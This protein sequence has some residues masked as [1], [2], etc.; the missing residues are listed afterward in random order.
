MFRALLDTNVI[1][2][3]TRYGG[4]PRECLRRGLSGEVALVA[5][6]ELLDEL[7]RTLTRR[8]AMGAEVAA[9]IRRDIESVSEI[10]D[11]TA[12][13]RVARDPAD[14]MVVAAARAGNVDHL[15]TGDRDLLELDV[16][17][18]SIVTPRRFIEILDAAPDRVSP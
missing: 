10:V 13:E 16:A 4:I 1:I 9:F 18:L 2:S 15:V 11:V 17:G 6:R 12:V 7:E 3:A 8:F 5:S 14:D